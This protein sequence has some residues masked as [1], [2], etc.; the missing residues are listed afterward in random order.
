MTTSPDQMSSP[1]GK[2]EG[3]DVLIATVVIVRA[4]DGLSEALSV[5]PVTLHRGD[6]VKVVLDCE[7]GEISFPG[8]KNTNALARKHKLITLGATIVPEELV[9][10]ALEKTKLALE[11]RAGIVR[12]DFGSTDPDAPDNPEGATEPAEE[13][14]KRARGARKQQNGEGG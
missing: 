3:E 2:F 12:L 13:K 14:P 8:I 4:G 9:A 11:E 7:V 10:E 1:L 6:R 5:H